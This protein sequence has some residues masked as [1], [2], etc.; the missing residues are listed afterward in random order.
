MEDQPEIVDA[1]SDE[2]QADEEDTEAD[3]EDTEADE[4]DTEDDEENEDN[5]TEGDEGIETLIAPAKK[6]PIA[7]FS[8]AFSPYSTLQG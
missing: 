7:M 5:E 8:F 2:E 4:E 3:E 6:R 1:A